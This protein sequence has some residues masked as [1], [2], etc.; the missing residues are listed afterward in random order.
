M[1]NDIVMMTMHGPPKILGKA[2]RMTVFGHY[3]GIVCKHLQVVWTMT[4]RRG[5]RPSQNGNAKQYA[6]ETTNFNCEHLQWLC[7][8]NFLNL[9]HIQI[10][11]I[12]RYISGF[13]PIHKLRPCNVV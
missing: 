8:D 10:H 6:K 1:I 13:S 5:E 2:V 11:V 4:G 7:H 9:R 3:L 12:A